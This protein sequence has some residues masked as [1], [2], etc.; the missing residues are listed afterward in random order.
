VHLLLWFKGC[1]VNY[2][3]L[4]WRRWRQRGLLLFYWNAYLS[5]HK[6]DAG[7]ARDRMVNKPVDLLLQL[8]LQLVEVLTLLQGHNHG[9]GSVWRKHFEQDDALFVALHCLPPHFVVPI[10]QLLPGLYGVH[11][12][13]ELAC[14]LGVV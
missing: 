11:E 6:L 2:L 3:F 5:V 10:T 14:G 7:V 8:L 12:F 13:G 4:V 9:G 1:Q